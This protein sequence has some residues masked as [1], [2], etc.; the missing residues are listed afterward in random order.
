MGA[1]QPALS[2]WEKLFLSN[3]E[4]RKLE[5]AAEASE[6]SEDE[7]GPS[8]VTRVSFKE[9]DRKDGLIHQVVYKRVAVRA[10]PSIEDKVIDVM[11]QGGLYLLFEWDSAQTWRKLHW[12]LR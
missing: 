3:D 2:E 7:F 10:G 12:Q 9:V 6:S 5:A 4:I 1:K 8:V 11:F